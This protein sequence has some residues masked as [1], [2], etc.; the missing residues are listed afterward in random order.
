MNIVDF[1]RPTSR[2]R[3]L[4][5]MSVVL[6]SRCYPVFDTITVSSHVIVVNII[7][8]TLSQR[9]QLLLLLCRSLEVKNVG[10]LQDNVN[11]AYWTCGR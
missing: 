1:T 6:L 10:Q 8:N 11:N 4:D 2:T 9:E 3:V 5:E 7:S